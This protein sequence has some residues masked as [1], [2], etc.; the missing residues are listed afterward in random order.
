MKVEHQ[1]I[2]V[3][4]LKFNAQCQLRSST[5]KHTNVCDIDVEL[6][7]VSKMP[8]TKYHIH[9]LHIPGTLSS[10]YFQLIQLFVNVH[11]KALG[12]SDVEWQQASTPLYMKPTV[13]FMCSDINKITLCCR[14]VTW[15]S[16]CLEFPKND[17]VFHKSFRL[18]AKK[19]PELY[20]SVTFVTG[21]HLWPVDPPQNV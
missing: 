8:R 16:W 14:D 1:S 2:A 20:I 6:P 9:Y 7:I 21:M 10:N 12:R 15:V 19:Q 18:A 11:Y 3:C 4:L 17:N 5:Q 13:I